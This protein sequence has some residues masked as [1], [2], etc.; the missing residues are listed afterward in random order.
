MQILR[1]LSV[2]AAVAHIA[3]ILQQHWEEVADKAS[4]PNIVPD[5]DKYRLLAE[6]GNIIILLAFDEGTCIGYSVSFLTQH[7]HYSDKR[8]CCNDVI[9]VRKA[10]RYTTSTGARLMACTKREAKAEGAAVMQWHAKPNSDLNDA[11]AKRLPVFEHVYT[12][13]L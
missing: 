13:S 5:Y 10:E 9:F 6:T 1:T 7:L 2:E 8:V 3:P 11:L 12:E 4:Y